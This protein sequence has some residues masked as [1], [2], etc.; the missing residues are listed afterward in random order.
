VARCAHRRTR[1]PPTHT[2]PSPPRPHR[3]HT[4]HGALIGSSGG[5]HV[6]R[7]GWQPALVAPGTPDRC[8]PHNGM[9]AQSAPAPGEARLGRAVGRRDGWCVA[10][11]TWVGGVHSVGIVLDRSWTYRTGHEHPRLAGSRYERRLPAP[12]AAPCASEPV[13]H[14]SADGSRGIDRGG[15]LAGGPAVGPSLGRAIRRTHQDPSRTRDRART[16]LV[17]TRRHRDEL[18]GRHGRMGHPPPRRL[19]RTR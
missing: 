11:V 16:G 15:T 1:T 10:A 19:R 14:S 17:R 12:D 3:T 2:D 18:A 7:L 5:C 4:R 9:E 6:P 13:V 8:S